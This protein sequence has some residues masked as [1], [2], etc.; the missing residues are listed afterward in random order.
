[1][2]VFLHLPGELARD[3]AHDLPE[4]VVAARLHQAH[5]QQG[6]HPWQA[7][8]DAQVQLPAHQG[9]GAGLFDPQRGVEV[10]VVETLQIGVTALVGHREDAVKP[11][12]LGEKLE[13]DRGL[14][15]EAEVAK[16]AEG[17]GVTLAAN[18]LNGHRRGAATKPAPMVI[19]VVGD[20]S[21][22]AAHFHH[23]GKGAGI[24]AHLGVIAVAQLRATGCGGV[25]V[26][27]CGR[28]QQRQQWQLQVV[29]L[30]GQW[31]SFFINVK[32]VR[33][34]LARGFDIQTAKVRIW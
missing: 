28:Q 25:L 20:K 13:T 33:G 17:K 10:N 31:A 16:G 23:V 11:L 24:A 15:L 6:D 1:M 2:E 5:G 8:P 12:V 26:Q 14:H 19:E 18:G 4:Q 7:D 21:C 27:R 32:A 34:P 9:E 3:L 22:A 29:G 30:V